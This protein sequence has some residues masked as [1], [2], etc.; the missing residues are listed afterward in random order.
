MENDMKTFRWAWVMSWMSALVLTG[1]EAC[2]SSY[3]EDRCARDPGSAACQPRPAPEAERIDEFNDPLRFALDLERRW[4]ALPARGEARRVP[5]T[6]TYWPTYQDSINMRWDGPGSES[7]AA[8]YGK[9]FGMDNLENTVSLAYGIDSQRGAKIC[10]S[11]E[12]CE[13]GSMCAIRAGRTDGRCI[14]GWF[15]LC[16]AWAPAAILEPEPRNAV[17]YNGVTFKVN[18]LKALLTFVYNA[19]ETRFLSQRCNAVSSDGGVVMDP[20][21]RPLDSACRDTNPGALHIVLANFLGLRGES[22]VEDRTFDSEVWNQP[23]RGYEI[24]EQRDVSAQEANRLIGLGSGGRTDTVAGSLIKDE[25]RRVGSFGVNE[26]G[27]LTIKVRTRPLGRSALP[28]VYVR[29]DQEPTETE[30]E[31]C[32]PRMDEDVAC[33]LGVP[34]GARNAHVALRGRGS[35][36]EFS[37]TVIHGDTVPASYPFNDAAARLVYVETRVRFISESEPGVD[38]NLGGDVDTYTGSDTYR[39]VL[40]ID[41]QGRIIGGE[42]AGNSRTDHPDFLWLPLRQNAPTVAG[43]SYRNVRELVLLS[44]E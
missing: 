24:R 23:L 15:G 35:Q 11:R 17:T 3:D 36:V 18:D 12:D 21:S 2:S 42:W 7:A 43:I 34:A 29:F 8:K 10:R 28:E 41:S 16:H 44:L 4:S 1:L 19:V 32:V 14:P 40:E 27:T 6:G 9:A 5:W 31:K 38:G 30:F 26:G 33:E 39:Y 13:G 37:V 20:N 25:W 22:F